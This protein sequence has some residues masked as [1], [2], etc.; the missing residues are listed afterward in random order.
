MKNSDHRLSILKHQLREKKEGHFEYV[1]WKL[2]PQQVEYVKNLGYKVEPYL[3]VII[4]RKMSGNKQRYTGVIRDVARSGE[5][6]VWKMYRKLKHQ[7]IKSLQDYGI[8]FYA[9]KY[10][11]FL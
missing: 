8:Q 11:I 2:S 6:G 5:R 9:F 10:K 1:I 4:T 7:E 3:Y